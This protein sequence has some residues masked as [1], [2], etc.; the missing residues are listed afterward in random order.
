MSEMSHV[1]IGNPAG[2]L[3]QHVVAFAGADGL[4]T[5]VTAAA[6]LPVA[7]GPATPP[8]A[9][10]AG[11]TSVDAVAGPFAPV[12]GLPIWVSLSGDWSGSVQVMRSLDGG[13]TLQPLTLG[14]QPW[15]IYTTNANEPVGEETVA[16]ATYYLDVAL[17]S[18]SLAYRVQQ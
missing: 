10:L 2:F 18:G 9:P 17:S 12:A 6:P 15:A 14:G 13:A 3:T 11:Q 4:G 7:V 5:T 16:G 8:G 1:P